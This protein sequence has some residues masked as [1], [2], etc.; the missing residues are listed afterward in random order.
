MQPQTSVSHTETHSLK[1]FTYYLDKL[2]R[3]DEIISATLLAVIVILMGYGVITRYVFNA[4][5]SWVE[6]ICI[7]LFIW[8]T[9][10]GASALMRHDEVV[11]IDY[12]VR[13]LPTKVCQSNG[14]TIPPNYNHDRNCVYGLLGVQTSAPLSS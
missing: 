8:M 1:T 7:A 9:F 3:L 12:L 4:P 13:K 11:R 5:S 14:W 2:S 6:E 10:M